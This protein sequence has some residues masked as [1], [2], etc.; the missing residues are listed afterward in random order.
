[1]FENMVYSVVMKGKKH[2][3]AKA[4]NVVQI[5]AVGS[6]T[7]LFA[8]LIVTLYTQLCHMA[9][10]FA[11]G[12]Y[13]FFRDDPTFI[14]LLMLALFT[15][16]VVVG[17]VLKFLPMIRGS[18]VPQAEGAARGAIKLRWF[19][20]LTGMFAVSLFCI[21]SGLSAGSEGP[22]ILIGGAC[23][24]GT[25]DLLKRNATMRRYQ[26][27]GGACAG[28]AVAFNAPFTGMAFAFEEAHKRFT[29]EVFA[30]AFSSVISAVLT[31][32]FLFWGF[33]LPIGAVFGSFSFAGVDP[34]D[35][36]F[37]AYVLG[38]SIVC[39]FAG[40]GFYYLIFFA[41][42]LLHTRSFCKGL[43][44]FFLPFL[45][46]GAFGLIS[47]YAIGG[48]SAFISDLGAGGNALERVFSSPVWV[49][50]IVVVVVKTIATAIN[51]G[52]GLPCGIFV[53]MLAIG[54]GL[55]ALL[56]L[57]CERIGMDAAYGDALVFICMATFFT[58]VVRAPI[59][60]IVMIVEL[61][62]SF[63]FLL[64]AI[65]GV[66]IGYVVGDTLRLEPIYEKMLQELVAAERGNTTRVTLKQTFAVTQDSRVCGR[67]VRDVLWPSGAHITL[68]THGSTSYIPD[69][70]SVLQ[71][72]DILSVSAE[73]A[74]EQA[75]VRSLTEI[76][77]SEISEK[78]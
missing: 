5:V 15:G 3:Y 7:G 46:A 78:T 72:G 45:T 49:T 44:K 18:G 23:G 47:A 37:Y 77:G 61:T 56:A 12:Y 40:V 71:E 62:F 74:D 42:K 65:L 43:G 36:L 4:N 39:A 48:G 41:R 26:I 24:N 50:L 73:T 66:A 64:P 59:T 38:A 8:G 70:N 16:A 29:P 31:R 11:V 13:G 25:S 54:A 55:G 34:S 60:G 19:R 27:T 52:V 21:F 58:T 35:F 10:E 32:N 57:L 14:P 9:E 69:G 76:I 1:M 75:L 2:S 28:L 53:P 67:A 33:D 20:S 68:V 22:S 17:G 30:C 51:A 6:L 63:T